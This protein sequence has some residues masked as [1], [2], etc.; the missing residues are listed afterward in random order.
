[1]CFP[2]T[3]PDLLRAR[4]VSGHTAQLHFLEADGAVGKSISYANLYDI[5]AVY[6]RR[7]LA[8]GLTPSDIVLGGFDDHQNQIYLFWACCLAGIPVCLLL[9]LHPD[10]TQ[11]AN[12]FNHLQDLFH[13]PTLVTSVKIMKEVHDV[14]PDLKTLV[15]DELP[16][17]IADTSN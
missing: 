4:A 2:P 3:L 15:Q 6:A 7:L 14:V 10:P 13:K 9:A 12:L 8:A 1:M 5:A 11:Q 16:V 17:S